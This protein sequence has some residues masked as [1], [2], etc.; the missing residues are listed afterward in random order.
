MPD[1]GS[2]IDG[3]SRLIKRVQILAKCAPSRVHHTITVPKGKCSD[4]L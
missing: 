1:Q 3:R 2:H 4:I